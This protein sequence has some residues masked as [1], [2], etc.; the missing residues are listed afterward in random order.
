M[1]AVAAET[2]AAA[3]AS[4]SLIATASIGTTE[5]SKCIVACAS[6]SAS[7]SGGACPG[8]HLQADAAG[9]QV[10]HGVNEVVQAAPSRSSFHT[11]SVS[12][13]RSALRHEARPGRSRCAR[14]RGVVVVEEGA[15]TPAAKSAVALQFDGQGAVCLDTRM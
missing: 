11:R 12:P 3:A 14:R 13:S 9:G 2:S 15:S 4:Q 5:R 6:F 7:G 1:R 10:V 8:E